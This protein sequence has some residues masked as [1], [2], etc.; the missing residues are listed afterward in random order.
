MR[1]SR[2]DLGAGGLQQPR[3]GTPGRAGRVVSA[4]LRWMIREIP[5][6]PNRKPRSGRGGAACSVRDSPTPSTPNNRKARAAPPQG[7]GRRDRLTDPFH[8]TSASP[9]C[10]ARAR[11]AREAHAEKPR[12]QVLA[13]A[14]FIACRPQPSDPTSHVATR[15]PATFSRS[16]RAGVASGSMNATRGCSPAAGF[17]RTPKSANASGPPPGTSDGPTGPSAA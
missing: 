14:R 8:I 17:G 1:I 7:G 16:S 13:A 11:A 9:P 3:T 15:R 10:P 2:A 5:G 6:S 4:G 12:R